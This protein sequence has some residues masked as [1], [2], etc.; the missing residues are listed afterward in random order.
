M[1]PEFLITALIVCL[2]PG[3]GVVYTVA[4][5]LAR[6]RRDSIYAAIGCTFGIVP[7]LMACIFGL[8]AILYTSAILFQ[9]VKFAGVAYLMYLAWMTLKERGPLGIESSEGGAKSFYEIVRTGILINT[10]NPKLAVFF[11]AFLPQFI[12]PAAGQVTMQIVL[13]GLV[14]MAMTFVTFVGYGLFAA[15]VGEAILKSERVLTWM[16]RTVALA[17]AGFGLRLAFSDR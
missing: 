16:R 8:A 5:G 3:T 4:T 13:L 2:V 6:G 17:F 9:A 14:F 12:D 10:L 1:S 11:M 15:V 7:A